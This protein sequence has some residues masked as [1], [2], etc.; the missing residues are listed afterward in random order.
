MVLALHHS[1]CFLYKKLSPS[2]SITSASDALWVL[3]LL[4]AKFMPFATVW[5]IMIY[6]PHVCILSNNLSEFEP[7]GIPGH[8]LGYAK[9]A[10]GYLIWV[11]GAKGCRGLLKMCWDVIFHDFPSPKPISSMHDNLSPL[12]KDVIHSNELEDWDSDK[13][14]DNWVVGTWPPGEYKWYTGIER[15]GGSWCLY[16][17]MN[18]C[19]LSWDRNEPWLMK[20]IPGMLPR[21]MASPDLC[22]INRHHDLSYTASEHTIGP[23]VDR[24]P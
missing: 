18:M 6:T 16:R 17:W 23:S 15:A 22:I 7:C 9:D 3:A 10:K 1:S 20:K 4:Q 21:S 13:N 14:D 8:F 2:L 19:K 5:C 11:P 12:W 24:K